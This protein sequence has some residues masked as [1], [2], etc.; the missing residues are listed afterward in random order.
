MT[1]INLVNPRELCDQHLVAEYREIPRIGGLLITTIN[2]GRDLNIPEEFCLGKG[3]T[4]FFL[5]K[6]QF[7]RKRFLAIREE[8]RARGFRPT[9]LWRNDWAGW[10][11][12]NND[13][14]PTPQALALS[15]ERVAL[16]LPVKA[17]WTPALRVMEVA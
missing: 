10:P 11:C 15:E 7:L 5:N 13:W 6:G 8:M 2:A 12:M 3:H 14:T 1:R 4:K 17:R 16:R 9:F